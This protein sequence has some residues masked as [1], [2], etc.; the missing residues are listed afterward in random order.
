MSVVNYHHGYKDVILYGGYRQQDD[1]QSGNE[2]APE[3]G[4]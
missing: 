2:L 4:I 3:D 1:F